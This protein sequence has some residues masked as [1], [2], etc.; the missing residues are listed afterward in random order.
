MKSIG[1]YGEYHVLTY[2]LEQDIEVCLA[3]NTNQPY[4]DLIAILN[5]KKIV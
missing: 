5:Q 3:I 4:Y 2:L 1:K